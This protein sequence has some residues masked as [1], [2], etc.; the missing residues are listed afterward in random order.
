MNHS[1]RILFDEHNIISNALEV[2]KNADTLIG[3]NDVEYENTIREL[4]HFFR[5]YADE[6]HHQKE[7]LI[8][9]PEM[10]KRNQM[11]AEGV[12][13][14]MVDNHEDFRD[15]IRSI[16]KKLEEKQYTE[17]QKLIEIYA[18]ALLDHIAAENEE[19]FPMA[20]TLMS[21]IELENIYYRFQ[22]NDRELGDKKK[23]GLIDMSES[24]RK[25]LYDI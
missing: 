14:E 17:A 6:Y 5:S 25:I 23:E 15:M 20:E 10:I 8:L 2:A 4:I 11:L 12:L 21:E 18:N 24:L 9:F 7:E 3:K 16:E 22:D 1:L 19:V 13:K